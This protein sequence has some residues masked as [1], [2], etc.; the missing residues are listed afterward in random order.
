ME[1]G[2]AAM[3]G[4]STCRPGDS[5]WT[6]ADLMRDLDLDR[7][8]VVDDT[9]GPVGTI[10]DREILFSY[11]SGRPMWGIA[12]REVMSR[13]LATLPA[14]KGTPAPEE[15][16]DPSSARVLPTL[17]AA[18]PSA[19][20]AIGSSAPISNP[21]LDRDSVRPRRIAR[22]LSGCL[23]EIPL[24]DLLQL[25][26]A[27]RRS[28]VLTV[29]DAGHEGLIYLRSGKVCYCI[30]DADPHPGPRKSFFRIV[31]WEHGLF[32]LGPP[33]GKEF[34]DELED[35]NEALLMEALRQLDEQREIQKALPP[36]T[37][38]LVPVLPLAA[39]LHDLT[40]EHLDVLQLALRYTHL[41]TVLDRSGLTDR[42]TCGALLHLLKNDY[43]RVT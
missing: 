23:E 8:T 33:D 19:M 34:P 38:S 1:R 28:G 16:R 22:A 27:S 39:P 20:R 43:L 25:L 36:P 3:P 26:Q 17:I 40:P 11:R 32:E 29:S 10:T 21:T 14:A 35:S 41:G 13:G 4:A 12:V 31:G 2:R 5:L 30:I 6:A 15:P 9:R 37:A 7:L 42:D 24:P 18:D